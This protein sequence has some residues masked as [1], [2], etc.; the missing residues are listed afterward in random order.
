VTDNRM[1][2]RL[3]HEIASLTDIVNGIA[4]LDAFRGAVN[5]RQGKFKLSSK[6]MSL[7]TC[8]FSTMK[9]PRFFKGRFQK[10]KNTL[11]FK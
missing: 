10:L 3:E 11:I 4:D 5:S 6:K 9:Y 8:V 2:K 7:Q 1:S